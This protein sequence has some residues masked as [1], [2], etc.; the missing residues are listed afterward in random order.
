MLRVVVVI[1]LMASGLSVTRGDETDQRTAEETAVRQA[2]ES[3]VT[4][5]NEGD[6]ASLAG[7]WTPDAVYTNFQTGEDVTGRDAIQEQFTSIFNDTPGLRLEVA[8]ESIQFVSPSV[9]IEQGTARVLHAELEPEVSEYTAIFVKRDDQ[10]LL[11]RVT[12]DD[13]AFAPTAHEH[14]EEL[15]WMIGDWVDDDDARIETSCQ[16]TNNRSFITR[17]FTVVVRDRLEMAGMQFVG[18]DPTAKQIRSW[19]F[20]SDGGF[21]EGVWKK[22]GNAWHIHAA[23]TLPDGR[24]SSGV[25]ILTKVDDDTF[26]WQSVQRVVD[27]E[28]LPNVD[29]VVVV[30]HHE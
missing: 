7:L 9:A 2:I 5:F 25:N 4:A 23:A 27:G 15:E 1:V 18:W 20:D 10:W 22:H 30:R 17:S 24:K 6:A 12:E 29:D 14:L 26:T 11:D 13:G 19:V 8:T 16:W 3:Y 21:G 28:L